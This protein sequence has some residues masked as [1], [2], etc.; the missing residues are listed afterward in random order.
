MLKSSAK[1][2]N[3]ETDSFVQLCHAREKADGA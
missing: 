1:V 3:S 2:L